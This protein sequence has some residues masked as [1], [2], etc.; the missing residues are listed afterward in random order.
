MNVDPNDGRFGDSV[1]YHNVAHA[2]AMGAGYNDP[3]GRGLT[4]Q[5]PPA[6]PAALAVLYKL[7]GW[8]LAPAKGLNI[9]FAAVTIALTYLL[10]RRIF[11][12]R[13]AFLG[14]M[15]LAIFPGQIYFSTLVLAESMF[16]MVFLLVLLLALAWTVQRP[17]SG[18]WQVLLIGL[19]VGLAGMVRAE[20]VFLAVVLVALWALTVRP[21]R[22][23]A[24]Y[25]AI[26]ALGVV[27]ALTPWTVRNAI[28]LHEFIPLRANAARTIGSALD[29]ET[30]GVGI[31]E[32]LPGSVGEGL[33]Y[34]LGH[35]WEFLSSAGEK[36]RALYDDD[37][38]GIR[39][40]QEPALPGGAPAYQAPL[41]GEEEARWRRLANGYFFAVG[42]AALV[43]AALCLLRRNRASLILVVAGLG[44]TLL[45]TFFN[46]FSRYHFP[47]VPL[48]AILAAALA[49]FVWDDAVLRRRRTVTQAEGEQ[50]DL[51]DASKR[52]SR[53]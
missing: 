43:A 45:F 22:T 20:G 10:A 11:D 32:P 48:I 16:A 13:V 35:P 23:V 39:K 6:Y 1:F 36:L 4:A 47:I 38:D 29:P 34:Q 7:F 28:Q 50:A 3:W 42:A 53:D 17:A 18:W 52:P 44:W 41:S 19:L 49:V 24:R 51:P 21:W 9:A 25:G 33:S 37:A 15:L 2:L 27:L 12:R 40:I 30:T 46:A 31:G 8:H 26:T 14:A 5:W